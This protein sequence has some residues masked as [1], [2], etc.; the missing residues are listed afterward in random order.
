MCIPFIEVFPPEPTAAAT[1]GSMKE[2]L[3]LLRQNSF[4]RKQLPRTLPPVEISL[5]RFKEA[6]KKQV[7][8]RGRLFSDY[9]HA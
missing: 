5:L 8:Q 6:V 1:N 4:N 9:G 7:Q 3:E 2:A